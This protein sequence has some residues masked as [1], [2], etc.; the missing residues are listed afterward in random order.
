[1]GITDREVHDAIKLGIAKRES[2]FERAN[3]VKPHSLDLL[4]ASIGSMDECLASLRNL[5]ADIDWLEDHIERHSVKP[6]SLEVDLRAAIA[7]LDL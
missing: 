2:L 5:K 4:D 1:M 7:G 3:N 6:N